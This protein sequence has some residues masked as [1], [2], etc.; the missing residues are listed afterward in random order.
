M[1]KREKFILKRKY[2]FWYVKDPT[3]VDDESLVEAVLNLGNWNDVRELIKLMGM[4]KIA[5][6]FR[7]QT[8]PERMRTNYNPMTK[9]YFNLYFDKYF[10]RDTEFEKS[11]ATSDFKV[12]LNNLRKDGVALKV[13]KIKSRIGYLTIYS[14]SWKTEISASNIGFRLIKQIAKVS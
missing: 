7:E 10:P 1:T 3:K 5:K 2:L 4:K 14:K 6:I 9:N 13:S 12:A 11:E 8:K